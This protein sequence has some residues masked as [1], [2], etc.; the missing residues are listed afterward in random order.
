MRYIDV[1]C[2]N[3]LQVG[4]TLLHYACIR[5]DVDCVGLL[6]A[7][8]SIDVSIRNYDRGFVLVVIA[9]QFQHS[10]N[11]FITQGKRARDVIDRKSSADIEVSVTWPIWL[12]RCCYLPVIGNV[13]CI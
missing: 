3:S 10:S 12:L 11:K 2:H 7:S 6:L 8:P 9:F 1:A 4:N 13:L 5:G